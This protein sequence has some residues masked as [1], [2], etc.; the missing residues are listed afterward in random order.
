MVSFA[1]QRL[2]SLIRSYL[3]IFISKEDLFV[4]FVKDCT[5]FSSKSCIVS[6]LTFNSLIHFEFIF[7][8]G[9]SKCYNFILLHKLS[10]FP[11]T[12][13]GSGCLFLIVYS[14]LFCQT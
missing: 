8:Y 6:G 1:V 11:S 14:H 10:S 13:Y 4:T 5:M 12:T 9:V 3:F 7:A 2:L